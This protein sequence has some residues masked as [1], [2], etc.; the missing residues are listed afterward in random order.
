MLREVG[1]ARYAAAMRFSLKWALAAMAYTAWAAAALGA[2]SV[3]FDLGL[4]V[5]AAVAFFYAALLAITAR[6]KLRV[7]ATGFVLSL[8]VYCACLYAFPYRAPWNG[9][10]ESTIRPGL[11]PAQRIS[12]YQR[13]MS[14]VQL[15]PQ[16]QV[17]GRSSMLTQLEDDY[18]QALRLECINA[19][20][21]MGAGLIGCGLGALAYRRAQREALASA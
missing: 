1:A 14:Q 4:W 16:P 17:A 9:A 5:V 11:N 15:H 18:V 20:G 12:E 2:P 8:A 21:A 3:F 13:L 19:I 7:L 10:F 6:G